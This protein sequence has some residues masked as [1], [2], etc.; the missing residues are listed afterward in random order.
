M[1]FHVPLACQEKK[2]LGGGVLGKFLLY[3]HHWDNPLIEVRSPEF[4]LLLLLK[5]TP[6]SQN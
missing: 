5:L 2:I 1:M 6:W 4:C 3:H